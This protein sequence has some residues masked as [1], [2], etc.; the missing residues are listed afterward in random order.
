MGFRIGGFSLNADAGATLPRKVVAERVRRAT[1][2]EIILA[3]MNRP[4]SPS[5]EGLMN[6]LV[7][8]QAGGTQFVRLDQVEQR[9]VK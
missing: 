3:H 4:A 1:D 2:G 5:T 8:L 7:S 6:G 9:R